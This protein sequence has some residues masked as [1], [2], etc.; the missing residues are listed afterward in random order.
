MW[1]INGSKNWQINNYVE[2]NK[3]KR[4]FILIFTIF[5]DLFGG[6]NS[7]TATT[8]YTKNKEADDNK[9]NNSLENWIWH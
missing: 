8:A 6:F 9:N 4:C 5:D 1:E 2:K 7:M 3:A